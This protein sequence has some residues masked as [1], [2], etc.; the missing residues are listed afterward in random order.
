MPKL[1]LNILTEENLKTMLINAGVVNSA[2]ISSDAT[3]VFIHDFITQLRTFKKLGTDEENPDT[4]EQNHR[5]TEEIKEAKQKRQRIATSIWETIQPSNSNHVK[6]GLFLINQI[7]NK[8]FIVNKGKGL[9]KI[10]ELILNDGSLIRFLPVDQA[11]IQ[12]PHYLKMVLPAIE[13]DPEMVRYI[14]VSNAKG[15]NALSDKDIIKLFKDKHNDPIWLKKALQVMPLTAVLKSKEKNIDGAQQ[16]IIQCILEHTEICPF[17]QFE[18]IK[19]YKIMMPLFVDRISKMK[20]D[21]DVRLSQYLRVLD[22]IKPVSV[23]NGN[24]YI[25]IYNSLSANPDLPEEA[26]DKLKAFEKEIYLNNFDMVIP[27]EDPNKAALEIERG[28]GDYILSNLD[29]PEC[30]ERLQQCRSVYY[31][32]ALEENELDD[33]KKEMGVGASIYVYKHALE[34]PLV[35]H[36]FYLLKQALTQK[37]L[38]GVKLNC[39]I[40]GHFSASYL[41]ADGGVQRANPRAGGRVRVYASLGSS[42]EEAAS[43]IASLITSNP[44]IKKLHLLGCVTAESSDNAIIGQAI[45]S[46][47]PYTPSFFLQDPKSERQHKRDLPIAHNL[48]ITEKSERNAMIRHN[49]LMHMIYDKIPQQRRDTIDIKAYT[50]GVFEVEDRLYTTNTPGKE[51]YLVELAKA[52]NTPAKYEMLLKNRQMASTAYKSVTFQGR[53]NFEQQIDR[54]KETLNSIFQ[55]LEAIKASIDASANINQIAHLRPQLGKIDADARLRTYCN[56]RIA[57]KLYHNLP[58]NIKSLE[59]VIANVDALINSSHQP[60][61]KR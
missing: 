13:Q 5:T 11:I 45:G 9:E 38:I 28:N 10:K 47:Q 22:F 41:A 59:Q 17:T 44:N 48:K 27:T 58:S 39:V 50:S 1:D 49:S 30:L 19:D 33:S 35:F 3:Q 54:C 7:D 61:L 2:D 6:I 29:K 20:V 46:F 25:D 51:G 31:Y 21:K 42:N 37:S 55:A 34:K 23:V 43:T 53:N 24:E 16:Q 57:N 14:N 52:T 56:E 60:G 36:D 12:P 40:S 8:V 15:S 32:S 4:E 26:R 18:N